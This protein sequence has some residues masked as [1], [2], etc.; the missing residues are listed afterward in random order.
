MRGL[1]L[2]AVEL[3]KRSRR[4]FHRLI[5]DK[6]KV[7]ADLAPRQF[8]ETLKVLLDVARGCLNRVEVDHEQSLG[9][10]GLYD[11]AAR[12]FARLHAAVTL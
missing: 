4:I 8:P 3:F 5:A 7:L 11:V 9:R 10:P 2:P 12:V 1:Y 6:R